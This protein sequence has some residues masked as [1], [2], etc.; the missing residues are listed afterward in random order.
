[1]ST[2]L[3]RKTRYALMAVS[4]LANVYGKGPVPMSRIADDNHIPLRFLEGIML[5]L[6]RAGMVDSARGVEG[7]YALSR[8][9]HEISLTEV[10]QA[11]GESLSFVSCMACSPEED[12]EFGRDPD[13]CGI[14]RVFSDI[15]A[16]ILE[17]TSTTTLNELTNR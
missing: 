6:K 4:A 17:K 16:V 12:C 5:Q 9:P 2:M 14:R 11:A 8:P 15:Y 13:T 7:G 10:I 1:M 3:T